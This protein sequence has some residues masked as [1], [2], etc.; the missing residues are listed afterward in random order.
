M[1]AELQIE[2]TGFEKALVEWLGQ[3]FRFS[4]PSLKDIPLAAGRHFFVNY[5][6]TADAIARTAAADS[7]PPIGPKEPAIALYTSAGPGFR[8][9]SSRGGKHDNAVQF[10]LRVS[11]SFEHA[12]ELLEELF[13]HLV[14][15]ARGKRMGSFIVKATVPVQR[16]TAFQR[17]GDD[18]YFASSS[19]RFLYV[20][21]PEA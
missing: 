6:P 1:T 5:L 12:K 20:S 13:E 18:R 2:L 3:T 11:V 17:Q 4:N 19:I 21:L 8:Q 9:S 16:P 15:H 10:V 14:A 7:F